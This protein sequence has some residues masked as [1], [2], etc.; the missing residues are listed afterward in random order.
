MKQIVAIQNGLGNQMF[1]YAFYLALKKIYPKARITTYLFARRCDHNGLEIDRIFSLPL[2]EKKHDRI[3][4]RMYRKLYYLSKKQTFTGIFGRYTLKLLY[5][6]HIGLCMEK[7]EI[8]YQG[9]QSYIWNRKYKVFWGGWMSEKWFLPIKEEIQECFSFDLQK[10]SPKSANLL[11][12]LSQ[13]GTNSISIH[14][15]RGDYLKNP[16]YF[17]ICN[18]TYYRK[19]I[20]LIKE[21]TDNARF[22]VF[23][24]DIQWV[25]ENL[26]LPQNTVYVNWNMKTD[27]WQDM[28]LMSHCQH[29][30]IANST[31]SWWGAWLNKNEEKIVI[32]P[33]IFSRTE[34]LVNVMPDE[35]IKI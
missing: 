15:R 20:G 25:K 13:T 18:T 9:A 30:I 28:C 21:K 12:E 26:D 23:S 5:I 31:F 32:C 8:P 19:A 6:L 29:H 2:S 35:W 17:D 34:N 3:M 11:E 4:M 27:S 33:Q 7:P 24:D 22:Y 10:L 14:V 16:Q 1:D